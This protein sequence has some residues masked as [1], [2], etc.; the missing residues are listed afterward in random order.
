MLGK[1]VLYVSVCNAMRVQKLWLAL[2]TFPV[3]LHTAHNNYLSLIVLVWSC[4]QVSDTLQ[5][6]AGRRRRHM[7]VRIARA[8][9]KERAKQACTSRERSDLYA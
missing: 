6:I 3:V 8:L 9:S 1:V 7:E 4:E 5:S 2:H